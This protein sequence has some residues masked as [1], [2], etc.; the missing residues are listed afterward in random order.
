MPDEVLGLMTPIL[1]L[2]TYQTVEYL[3][4]PET[5]Q[6]KL[7]SVNAFFVPYTTSKIL[8]KIYWYLL[9][10]NEMTVLAGPI[11]EKIHTKLNLCIYIYI[12]C[13]QSLHIICPGLLAFFAS[14]SRSNPTCGAKRTMGKKL[15][16]IKAPSKMKIT[17]WYFGTWLSSKWDTS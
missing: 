6:W 8:K 16:S 9:I 4:N 12:F 11:I 13:E 5:G 7:D 10:V 3:F 15:L 14:R 2:P 17:L 1:P